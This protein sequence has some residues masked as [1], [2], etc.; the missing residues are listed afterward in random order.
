MGIFENFI[1][2]LE[3]LENKD[4][5]VKINS[6]WTVKDVVSHLVGWEEECANVLVDSLKTGE[7]PWFLEDQDYSEF[8]RKNVERYKSYTPKKLLEKWKHLIKITDKVIKDAGGEERLLKERD[9]LFDGSHYI[10]HWEQIKRVLE[11]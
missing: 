4:W 8:N 11:K 10:E 5:N 1:K 9:W 3:R 2:Y 6:K 7:K